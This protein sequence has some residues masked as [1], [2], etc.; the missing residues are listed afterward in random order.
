MKFKGATI[1]LK[2][3]ELC[4]TVMLL[5][6]RKT[7]LY[8]RLKLQISEARGGDVRGQMTSGRVGNDV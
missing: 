4:F 7:L 3:D 5:A 6:F 8:T 2:S 1:P